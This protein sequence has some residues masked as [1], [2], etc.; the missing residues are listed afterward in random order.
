MR[1][2]SCRNCWRR[3]AG[4]TGPGRGGEEYREWLIALPLFPAIFLSD[5]FD[6]RN[7]LAHVRLYAV[8]GVRLS[9]AARAAILVQGFPAWG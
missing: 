5:H 7:V 8:H 9:Q 1:G 4:P 2:S 6:A 3:S